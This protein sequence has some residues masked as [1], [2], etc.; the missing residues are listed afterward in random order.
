MRTARQPLPEITLPS[1]VDVR[2]LGNA[3]Q[4]WGK[5]IRKDGNPEVGNLAIKMGYWL[6]TLD[7]A[8][9]GDPDWVMAHAAADKAAAIRKELRPKMKHLLAMKAFSRILEDVDSDVLRPLGRR[10]CQTRVATRY[11]QR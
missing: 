1:H 8:L 2:W 11:V 5:S 6:L 9:K 7:S 3:A 4:R 10:A